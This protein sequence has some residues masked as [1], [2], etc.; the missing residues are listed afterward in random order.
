M[1]LGDLTQALTAGSRALATE[2]SW[3]VPEAC[4]AV[5]VAVIDGVGGSTTQ[6]G[7]GHS[8]LS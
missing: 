5:A 3:L 7:G 8:D 1:G 2:T 4:S 6:S